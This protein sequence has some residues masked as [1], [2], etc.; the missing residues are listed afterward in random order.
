MHHGGLVYNAYVL[1]AF[2]KMVYKFENFK[3][4]REYEEV[5]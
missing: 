5:M 2:Q 3:L 1:P 4:D